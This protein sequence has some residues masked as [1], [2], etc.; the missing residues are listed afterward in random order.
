MSDSREAV[1]VIDM[2]Y[3]FMA[4]ES[5]L[6]CGEDAQQIIPTVEALLKAKNKAA[7]IFVC[8]SHSKDDPE[9][10]MF[11]PHCLEGTREAKIIDQL[12]PYADI[13]VKKTTIDA[14]YHTDLEKVLAEHRPDKVFVVGVCTDICVLYA[15]AGL[16]LRGYQVVVPRDCV[17]S[18]HKG[19]HQWALSHIERVLGAS[20]ERF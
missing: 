5:T 9:F 1:L 12:K 19:A 3:G 16:R 4:E 10:E 7:R 17:A 20:V 15:V 6:Y 11:P 18:F 2:L 13:V 8:D 14:F